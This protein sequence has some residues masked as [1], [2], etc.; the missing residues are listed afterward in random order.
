MI[1]V[2]ATK[3]LAFSIFLGPMLVFLFFNTQ[4]TVTLGHSS[5]MFSLKTFH[6]F[7]TPIF[8]SRAGCVAN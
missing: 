8:C 2:S 6:P 3:E 5:A 1:A 4:H 7:E